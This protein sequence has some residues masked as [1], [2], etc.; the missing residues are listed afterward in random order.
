MQELNIMEEF[1]FLQELFFMQELNSMEELISLQ[2]LFIMQDLYSIQDLA[3]TKEQSIKIPY[4]SR[5]ES[6]HTNEV[7]YQP[8]DEILSEANY[9]VSSAMKEED[10]IQ[11]RISCNSYNQDIKNEFGSTG[12]YEEYTAARDKGAPWFFDEH[13]VK[14]KRKKVKDLLKIWH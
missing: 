7:L 9:N 14:W 2:E 3:V 6:Y 5:T 10:D 1:K 12:A 13:W 8:T 11:Q 4:D